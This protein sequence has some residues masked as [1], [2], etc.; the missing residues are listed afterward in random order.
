MIDTCESECVWVVIGAWTSL[1]SLCSVFPGPYQSLLFTVQCVFISAPTP[2]GLII[3]RLCGHFRLFART[4]ADAYSTLY[5]HTHYV[6]T[7][8][9]MCVPRAHSR[10]Q[11]PSEHKKSLVAIWLVSILEHCGKW[12]FLCL[13]CIASAFYIDLKSMFSKYLIGKN[14]HMDE[15]QSVISSNEMIEMQKSKNGV[16]I[17]LQP[18]S[19]FASQSGWRDSQNSIAHP[20][21]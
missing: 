18:N 11:F 6:N 5:M 15:R 9:R 3:A 4:Y 20:K 19:S 12:A 2:L 14:S 13:L 10:M 16:R 7:C 8:T 17:I 21:Q 1:F